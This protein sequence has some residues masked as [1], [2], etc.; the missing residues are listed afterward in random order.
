MESTRALIFMVAALTVVSLVGF[1]IADLVGNTH[2]TVAV[3]PPP[4][5]AMK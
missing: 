5:C 2:A 3:D 1:R 4:V